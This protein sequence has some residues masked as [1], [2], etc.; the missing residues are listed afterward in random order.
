MIG[1]Y[2]KQHENTFNNTENKFQKFNNLSKWPQEIQIEKLNS[3]Y[4]FKNL[5]L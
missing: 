2:Y 1:K 4:L 3:L 5:I